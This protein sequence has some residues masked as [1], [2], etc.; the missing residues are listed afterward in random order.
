[1]ILSTIFS[2]L[3]NKKVIYVTAPKL[4]KISEILYID[5]QNCRKKVGFQVLYHIKIMILCHE[6]RSALSSSL[7]PES[8]SGLSQKIVQA[9]Q[10]LRSRAL[11]LIKK[12]SKILVLSKIA[13]KQLKTLSY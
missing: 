13:A 12:R 7:F 5:F 9:Y 2:T 8:P 1:L 6:I 10:S 11:I 3:L 4:E